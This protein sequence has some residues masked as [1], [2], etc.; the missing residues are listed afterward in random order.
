MTAEVADGPLHEHDGPE[1]WDEIKA[2]VARKNLDEVHRYAPNL[3]DDNILA[4]GIRSPL[5]FERYNARNW[6]GSCH[7]CDMGP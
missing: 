5:D 7:G 4:S 1:K 3:T 2:G 6:H